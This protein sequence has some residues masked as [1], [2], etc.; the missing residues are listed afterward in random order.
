MEILFYLSVALIIYVYAGYP[1]LLLL[2]KHLRGQRLHRQQEIEPKVTLIISAYN[3]EDVIA[4]KLKNSL[5]L[6]YPADKLEIIVISDQSSDATDEIV[7]GFADRGVKLH[8]MSERGGKTMGLNAVVPNA[9]G[10]IVIF[11]DAN[12]MYD[13][14]V[15]RMMVRNFADSEVGA[16]TGESRYAIDEGDTSTDSE[17]LYWRYE[18]ALKRMESGLGSLVGG[19]GAIYAIRQKLYRQLNPSDLSDFVN[20]LQIVVQGYRNVYEGEAFS[21]EK[22]GESFE[23]EFRRKVRIVNRAWRGMMSMRQLLNPLRYGFFAIQAISHKL[24][25][26]L[27]PVFMVCAFVSNLFLVEVE[28]FYR[29]MV[30]LQSAFYLFAGIGLLKREQTEISKI[31]Y[32]PYYFCLVNWASLKGILENYQGHTYTVWNTVRER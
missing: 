15:V 5:E 11:S 9:E 6:D 31:F 27:V 30:L 32:V 4:K 14:N 3:E 2:M 8:R 10:E 13:R 12:A 16:V 19:D 24:L 18:L 26:W 1:V 29:V 20:P 7:Q 22:G 21:Y 23:K 28:P 25:R 17:N